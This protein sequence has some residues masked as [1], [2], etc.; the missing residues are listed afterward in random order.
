MISYKLFKDV[1]NVIDGES[2]ISI[3]FKN[4]NNIYMIVKYN[5][6]V[7]FQKRSD[8]LN[9]GEIKYKTLDD[10]YNSTTIDEINLKN[11]WD[12]IED[13][14]I[15]DIFSFVYDKDD[16]ERIYKIDLK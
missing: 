15:D 8:E 12:K 2:E 10:L 4:N 5:D 7:T 6:R 9:R 3:Y 11:D 1:F 16:I 13:I 14:V